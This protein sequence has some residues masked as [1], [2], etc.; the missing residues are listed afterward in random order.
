MSK[1]SITRS[2]LDDLAM[3][4][5]AKSG[6]PVPMTLTEMKD[7]VDSIQSGGGSV[8]QDQDGF[9][10]LPPDGG[11]SPS[12][13]GLEYET[14]T[15]TPSEDVADYFAPFS[16]THTELP[17]FALIQVLGGYDDTINS[18]VDSVYFN[19][20]SLTGV[21]VYPSSSDVNYGKTYYDYR[22]SSTTTFGGSSITIT[23]PLSSSDDSSSSNPRFWVTEAGLYFHS[24]STSRFWRAG[25][26]YKWIA[27]WAPTT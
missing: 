3:S 15:W 25:K 24:R 12:V 22:G 2:L 7:A 20:E 8:T 5:S 4:I 9:I 11:G 23:T 14:G 17:F 6:E 16:K 26:Q 10:I 1:V 27:V 21:G 19:F 13:G 18:P